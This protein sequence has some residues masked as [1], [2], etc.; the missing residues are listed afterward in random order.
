[1][2][3]DSTVAN[4]RG[5]ER[6]PFDGCRHGRGRYE[7]LPLSVGPLEMLVRQPILPSDVDNVVSDR[8]EDQ[9]TRIALVPNC[10]PMCCR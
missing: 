3:D 4:R 2:V 1:M 9:L 5:G 8:G 6:Y 10:G 7:G